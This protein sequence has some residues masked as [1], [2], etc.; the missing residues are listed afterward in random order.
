MP[1][2]SR[3]PPSLPHDIEQ[4][5]SKCHLK[6]NRATPKCGHKCKP[7]RSHSGRSGLKTDISELSTPS[8]LSLPSHTRQ[9]KPRFHT[10]DDKFSMHTISFTREVTGS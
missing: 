5:E 4:G 9:L 8:R 10:N 3:F 2:K 1:V 6:M 7:Q